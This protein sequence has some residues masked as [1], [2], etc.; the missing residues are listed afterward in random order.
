MQ[1]HKTTGV[2]AHGLQRVVLYARAVSTSTLA[3]AGVG[4]TIGLRSLILK[5]GKEGA[6]NVI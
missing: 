2:E 4:I 1:R 5:M 6:L 3:V